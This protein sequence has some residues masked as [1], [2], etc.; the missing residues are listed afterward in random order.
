MTINNEMTMN[1]NKCKLIIKITINAKMTIIYKMAKMLTNFAGLSALRHLR[2]PY[3]S[4]T[5]QI[6]MARDN[7]LV[8]LSRFLNL[9]RHGNHGKLI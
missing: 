6:R 3:L 4:D 9:E 1:D 5:Y 7:C 2:H 8:E